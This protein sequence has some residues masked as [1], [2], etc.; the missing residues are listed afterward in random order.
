[1]RKLRI[2]I[3][4]L[5]HNEP[6]QSL[7]RRIMFPNYIGIMPQ[8]IGVW[9]KQ[10]GH[11]VNYSIFT[12]SQKIGT[13]TQDHT[14]LVFISSFTYSAQLAYSLSN[15]YRSQGIVTV[16]GGPHARSYPENASRYFDYVLGLTDKELLTNLLNN[17]E[18]NRPKGTYVTSTAQPTSLPGVR[19]RWEFIEKVLEQLPLI[20][21]VPMI[22][23][24][25]CPY[26]CDFCVDSEMQYQVL[27]I[28]QIKEDLAFLTK[29]IKYP[30][31][32]W[33]D[34][35]FGINFN[36]I[37]ETIESV[38]PAGSADFIAECSLSILKE[39]NVERLKR[40]G[41]KM[42]MPGI[43]SWDSYG[44][45]SRL[46]SVSGIE[47][48]R[49]V[50]D[51]VNMIQRYIPQ[52]QTNFIFGLD[53][54]SDMDPFTLT[55]RFIDLA[56]GAYPSYALMS[57][58]GQ[59]VKK[60]IIYENENRII[61]FPFHMMRSVHICNIIPKHYSWEVLYTHFIDLLKYS[62]SA[63]AMYRRFNANS[64]AVPKWLTLLLSLTI[65]GIGKARF[66]SNMMHMHNS[67]Q[68]FQR[69]VRKETNQVPAILIDRIKKELGPWWQWL[70]DK[71]LWYDPNV[72]S[73]RESQV[74]PTL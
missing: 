9:C 10:E 45:K 69:F 13:L 2:S 40:N 16:L 12:G 28:E 60:N 36:Q 37:M 73:K 33:Y 74:A 66:L 23:S 56:P 32:S 21:I 15:L 62:F 19:E 8:I 26:D 20:K 61:P 4:D 35:N 49:Q 65:G 50:A 44:K 5:I 25:G 31:I 63:K 29:K 54:N 18:S 38:I 1:M 59:S 52:V 46:A 51:Q 17:F 58:Y 48:V 39:S 68:D 47:K 55:K 70:P 43:E 14:D 7:Y 53:D 27:D 30:R 11:E 34:P 22:G 71:S 6:S 41:F 42:I 3:I 64:M 67:D 72:L 57:V 24:M